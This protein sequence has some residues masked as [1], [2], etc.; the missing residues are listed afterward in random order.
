MAKRFSK[1]KLFNK[2]NVKKIPEDKPIVYRLKGEKNK[3][4]YT[5]VAKKSRTQERLSEHLTKKSEKIPGAKKFQVLQFSDIKKAKVAE[6]KLIKKLNPK[7]NK[8]E[9]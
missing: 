8:E 9:T 7:Y 6:K 2:T 5:G 1:A 4:L 3:E